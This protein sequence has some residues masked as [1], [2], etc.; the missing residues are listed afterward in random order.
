MRDE[1]K[2]KDQLIAEIALLRKNKNLSDAYL[3]LTDSMLVIIGKDKRVSFV[4]KRACQILGY[5]KDEIVGKDWFEHFLPLNL[6]AEV[7]NAAAAILRGEMKPVEYFEN[8]VL[9]KNGKEQIILWHNTFLKNETG[10]IVSILSSGGD[11]PERKKIEHDLEQQ[12][13]CLER[14]QQIGKIGSWELDVKNN[15]LIWTDETYEIFRL[16]L[17]IEPTYEIF[18]N[19]VHPDDREFVD[20]KWNAALNKEPYDIE[21]RLLCDGEIKWVREKAELEFDA[22]GSCVGGTGFT[23]DISER[24]RM[25]KSLHEANDIINRSPAVAFLWK[26]EKNWPVEFV[27]ENVEELF[28]YSC[29]EFTSGKIAYAKTI[30]PADLE[31]VKSEVVLYSADKKRHSFEHAPYRIITK[32]GEEKWVEDI[33]YIRRND[34]GGITY[35][36]GIIYDITERAK[37]E[38]EVLISKN[39]FEELFD[40]MSSCAAIYNVVDNGEDFVFMDFNKA[41]Q[42]A[43]KADKQDL[44]G[45]RVTEVFP[46]VKDFGLLDVLKRVWQTGE[47]EYFPVK[48][49]KE[50]RISGWRENHVYKLVTGELV[51]IYEDV[52]EKKKMEEKEKELITEK[53]ATNAAK[54]KA[55]ELVMAY[56]ELKD[57]QMQLMQA[58]KLAGI[59]HLGAGMAHELNS[60]LTGVLSLLRS[61]KKEKDPSSIEYVDLQEM[62]KACVHMANIIKSL[63]V[64]ARQAT[65]AVELVDCND[66]IEVTLS[67]SGH[68]FK[69]GKVK[70]EK[71]Y[72]K[73]LYLIKASRNQIQQV[74]VNM[75]TNACDAMPQEGVFTITTRNLDDGKDKWVEMEFADTGCGIAQ[76]SIEKIFDP[77]FTTKRPGGGVGLGLSIAHRIVENHKGRIKVNSKEGQGTV[78]RVRLPLGREGDNEQ[79]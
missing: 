21:H 68:H 61:Y 62:E 14:A 10:D 64:F 63:N 52:T 71:N 55:L 5:E 49:Y 57:T 12:K 74:I 13:Y 31:R 67:F 8:P 59:G 16:P 46:G 65:E 47:P 28:G 72:E 29:E 6:R 56:Q 7:G 38:R 41:G 39:R 33:T 3:D 73:N 9:C 37:A 51:V 4:N 27:S 15:Q 25:E 36:E 48:E 40:N 11:I 43:E 18:L 70:I 76:E 24:K 22:Q 35:Y 1:D 26:N 32:N 69:S 58:E 19:C 77:F 78:F 34:D 75:I 44:I 17:G 23:Q 53:A 42:K 54:Q 45:R 66:A 79:S 50:E 2:N 30:Y 60:P 20:K